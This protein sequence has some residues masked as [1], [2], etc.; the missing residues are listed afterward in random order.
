MFEKFKKLNDGRVRVKVIATMLVMTLTFANFALLGSYMGKAISSYAADIDLSVQDD[1]TNIENVKFEAYLDV[2]DKSIKEKTA[3]INSKDLI[4]YLSVGVQGDGY[5]SDAKIEFETANFDTTNIINQE[6]LSIGTIQANKTK[7]LEIPLVAVKDSQYNLSL[8]NMVS[9]IRL[10]GEYTDEAGSVTNIDSTKMVKINWTTDEI[11]K[12]DIELNQEIITNKI[13]N[14]NGANKRVIQMLVTAKVKDNKA[15]IKSSTIEISNPEIGSNPEEVKVAGYTTKATNGKTSLEFKDTITSDWEYNAEEQKTTIVVNNTQNEQNIVSWEKNCEDKYVV[16]YVYDESVNILP[17]VCGAKATIE[18][19]GRTTGIIEKTNELSLEELDDLGNIVKLESNV[20]KNI[21]KGN[22]YIGE[23]TDFKT[24]ANIYVPYSNLANKIVIEDAGDVIT[25]TENASTYYKTTK[26]NRADALKVLGEEGTIIIYNAEDKTTPIQEI[27]LSEE[28]EEE[29]YII[30]YDGTVN[31]IAIEMSKAQTE[32]IIEII[33]EKAIKMVDQEVIPQITALTTNLKFTVTD[34]NSNA[35]VDYISQS[36]AN[37]LE[38]KTTFDITL[39]KTSL[40]TQVE[41]DLKITT[42]IKAVDASNKLF[43]NPVIRI[44]LPK[45]IKEASLENISDVLYNDE[46]TLNAE[47]SKIVTNEA[48]NKELQIVLEGKQTKYNAS[49]QN[50]TIVADLK[51]KTDEFMASKDV[52]INAT[53]VNG[54]E[55]AENKENIKL[56][57]KTGLITKNTLALGT[58]IIE[59]INQ[60]SLSTTISEDANINISSSIINNFEENLSNINIVGKIPEGTNLTSA[61]LTSTEG[62][63]IAYSEEANPTLDSSSWKTEVTDYSKIKSFKLTLSEMAKAGL[64]D[65]KYELKVD[66]KNIQESTYLVNDL[67]VNY[68]INEQAKEEKIAFTLNVE[69]QVTDP[70]I[71]EQPET[72][73]DPQKPVE[74]ATITITPKTTTNTLHEDQIVTY[75]IKVKNTSTETLSNVTLDYVVPQGAVVTELT[76]AQGSE[77]VF[78][79]NTSITNKTWTIQT[80]N[81]NQTITKEV[82]LKIKEEATDI[83]NSASLKDAE[84]TV[85]AQVTLEPVEVKEGNLTVRLSRRA[86]ME[87]ELTEGSQIIYVVLVKNNTNTTMNNVKI[88]SK[89]P[90]QTS[91]IENSEYNTNWNYDKNTNNVNYTIDTLAPG[92]TKD[93]RF[94]VK[95]DKLNATSA[96]IDNSAIVITTDGE[97]YETNLYTSNVLAP[98]WDIHMTSLHN[99]ILNEGD[100]VKYIIKVDNSGEMGSTVYVTDTLPDQ[101]NATKITYYTNPE[102]KIEQSEIDKGVNVSY[103][104]E[105]GETLII[106]LEGIVKELDNNISYKKITNV[107]KI[108]LGDGEYLES[109]KIVNTIVNDMQNPGDSDSDQVQPNSIAGIVWLDENKNGIRDNQEKVLQSIKVLLLDAKGNVVAE[110][111]TSLTGTYRFNEVANGD[112]MVAFEY[113]TSKYGLTKYQVQGANEK[114]N[115]D[116][117]SKE[118]TI[119]NEAKL[120]GIT[121]TIKISDNGVASVDMGLIESPEFDLSLN[122]Y[123]SK[124]VVTN[125]AG[126]STYTYED[127]ELAKV[128]ISA[129]QIAGTVLLVEYEIEITNDGDLNGYVTDIIDYLP[130]ELEFSSEMN[131]EWYLGSDNYL[132]YMALEP[133]A[134]ESGKTQKV[135]LVLTKTLKSNSTGTIDNIAEIGESTNL[136]GIKDIDSTAGNKQDGEDD[137]AKA[138]LIVSIKTG[139]PMMYVGIVII[140][141]IVLGAGIYIIDKKVLR[142]RI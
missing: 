67:S 105:I 82:T 52:V 7:T 8:L 72:P 36:T 80:I 89:I 22:M 29:Y 130:S 16:T 95:V 109:E 103:P 108:D 75:E 113:D 74:K 88:T 9:Q 60:N 141:M 10:T 73:E 76:Y 28:I 131:T 20:T 124:V 91:W 27:D 63:T 40:S 44:E 119:N 13:Y 69:K 81:P 24:K 114:I 138:S 17:F 34:E 25:E 3:D 100:T 85:I 21:Y 86:N 62:I 118:I 78:T 12:D 139:S 51:V 134:I 50:A 136:E 38:P 110:T 115:S 4:L 132:H 92:E 135:K 39:D 11:T 112:Y 116:V 30:S 93:V 2:S 33:N 94:E 117:I 31:K 98:K 46:L 43:D 42:E 83:I 104:V 122:K 18:L 123:I 121:D 106:E 14:I 32:G 19:Y 61:V 120:V 58:N 129:K 64:I 128:E 111:L 71:P 140:S 47:K 53:C 5:L 45:E 66:I 79:D 65:L 125:K 102:N 96:K 41:N 26:I 68:V 97:Q 55:N 49:T 90:D 56:V 15:P 70:E 54:T 133:Q 37:I 126:T 57:S 6:A 87:I 142:V 48:G 59:K 77:I 84:N 23:E 99:E 1:Q 137:I 127:T 107:A 35:F 101:I